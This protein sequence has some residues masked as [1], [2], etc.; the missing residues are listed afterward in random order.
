MSDK[1]TFSIS[2]LAKEFD[3][4]TEAFASTKTKDCAPTCNGQT[5]FS[6]AKTGCA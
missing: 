2:E 3:V 6:A 4:T 5:G 1:K